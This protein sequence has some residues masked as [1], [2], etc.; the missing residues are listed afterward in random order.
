MDFDFDE[1]Y[2]VNY[3]YTPSGTILDIDL[4]VDD[5]GDEQ[6][7]HEN[8]IAD[9]SRVVHIVEKPRLVGIHEDP[10]MLDRP[11]QRPVVYRVSNTTGELMDTGAN[12]CINNNL[13]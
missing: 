11:S 7:H 10:A 3:V 6:W 9:D 13:S 4:E 12:C 1:D 5:E 2:A 8:D